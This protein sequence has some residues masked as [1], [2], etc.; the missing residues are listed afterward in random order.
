MVAP[1]SARMS[2]RL[3]PTLP[4][5]W[6]ATLRPSI[7]RSCFRNASR[8]QNAAPRAVASTRPTEPPTSS[9]FPVTTP[10]TE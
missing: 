5:P 4:K 7:D 10:S 2:A 1:W 3:E 9:G 6:T 8:T